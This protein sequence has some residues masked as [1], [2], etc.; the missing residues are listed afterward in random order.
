MAQANRKTDEAIDAAAEAMEAWLRELPAWPVHPTNE[1][2]SVSSHFGPTILSEHD[3]VLHYSR[4][5]NAAEVN[6][7]D[8]HLELSPGQWMYS[9]RGDA[10]PPKRIDLT[11]IER[12]KLVN[13]DL[14]V[15]VGTARRGRR[16]RAREQLLG[17]RERFAAD[18]DPESRA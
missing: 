17:V 8:I 11:V 9:P 6:W 12:Q 3:C 18:R 10:K 7:E 5:L 14:P 15:P 2:G 13:A 16:L 4:F 1:S